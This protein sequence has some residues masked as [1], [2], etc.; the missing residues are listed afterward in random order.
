ME[1]NRCVWETNNG[2][3][4]R[5]KNVVLMD[6][7]CARH[8]KQKC[9][10][11]F[12]QV[13]SL[14]SAHTKKLNCGHSFHL[15]CI[16]GWFVESNTCPVCRSEQTANIDPLIQF[17]NS[18]EDNLREKYRDTIRSYEQELRRLSSLQRR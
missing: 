3:G 12:E 8:L 5:C 2:T 4:G 14:N 13:R 16:L 7:H 1:P 18:I 11:C 6:N 9:P 10:V 17:K 15:P